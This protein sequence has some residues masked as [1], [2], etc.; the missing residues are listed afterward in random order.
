MII[1]SSLRFK[2]YIMAIILSL[3]IITILFIVSKEFRKKA[4]KSF[5][6]IK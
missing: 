5:D 1:L 6:N 2:A 4:K 3:V